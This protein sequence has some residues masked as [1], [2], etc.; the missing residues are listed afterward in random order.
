MRPSLPVTNNGVL[1]QLVH[2]VA[3]AVARM[4]PD[5]IRD[6][7]RAISDPAELGRLVQRAYIGGA[8]DVSVAL[9]HRVI[10]DLGHT[11]LTPGM[12]AFAD[13]TD[14]SLREE[15]EAAEPEQGF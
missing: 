13:R 5:Q 1:D 15:F 2:A 14:P 9:A 3:D 4:P 7:A 10:K 11:D 6:G 8:A 12:H